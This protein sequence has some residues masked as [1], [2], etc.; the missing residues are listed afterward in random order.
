MWK[1]CLEIFYP[2]LCELCGTGLT[3]NRSL[4]PQC[5]D[6]LPRIK[7]PFCEICTESFT[8]KITDSF[9]CPN[10]RHLNFSFEFARAALKSNDDSRYLIHRFKY[11]RHFYLAPEF[12]LIMQECFAQ[13]ERLSSLSSPLIIPVPLHWWRQQRRTANQAYEIARQLGRDL[14]LPVLQALRRS[15]NTMTQTKLPRHERLKNLRNAFT[16]KSR[17]SSQLEGKTILLIDDV[18]TTGSTAHECGKILKEKGKVARVIALSLLR[19]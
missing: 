16:L 17:F 6:S 3:N 8:G 15:R 2:S 14:D 1:R 11:Q 7:A 18:F 12:S 19:G 9:T 4:C 13:D 5:H 10:C